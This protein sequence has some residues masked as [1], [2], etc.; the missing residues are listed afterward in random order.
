MCEA[1]DDG[2]IPTDSRIRSP[3]I[4]TWI[5]LIDSLLILMMWDMLEGYLIC[6][7]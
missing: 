4:L 5:A 7:K 1:F 2:K 6:N 3:H